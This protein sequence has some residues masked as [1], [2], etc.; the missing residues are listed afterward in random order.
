[1]E[2]NTDV[3]LVPSTSNVSVSRFARKEVVN[4]SRKPNQNNKNDN[5]AAIIEAKF[6]N[7]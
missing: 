1:M 7:K 3:Q 5:N 6:H 2:E 4:E